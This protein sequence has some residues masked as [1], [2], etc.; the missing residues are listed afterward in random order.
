MSIN[1][2]ISNDIS[3]HIG[4]FTVNI[5]FADEITEFAL[6]DVTFAAVSGNGLTNIKRVLTGSGATYMVNISVPANV[7]GAFSVAITGQVMVDGSSERVV[8]EA[9][10]FRYD[11]IVD[12]Q[13]EFRDLQY[14]DAE[15]EIILPIQFD[16]DVLWFDRSD[17]FVER[18]AGSEAYLLEHYVRGADADYEVV[19]IP[20]EGT[21]GGFTVDITGEVIKEADLVREII[22]IDPLLISY[23]NLTPTLADVDTPVRS[24]DGWWNVSLSFEYP[25]IGFGVHSII[26]GIEHEQSFI[27]RGLSMDVMPEDVPP[28]FSDVYVF[29]DVQRMHCVGN[30]KYVDLRSEEAGRYFW[31]KLRSDED[32]EPEIL[33]K[34]INGLRA[35]SVSI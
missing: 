31:V 8:A 18:K 11:T 19:F 34:D 33:L 32:K 15:N 14:N 23:N 3:T 22:H 2:V 27:Y 9:K 7:V 16:E 1:A 35:V 17:L 21:W 12:V 28:P 6:S 26:T 13:T 24:E 4:N 5:A 20:E 29:E 30:W 25:V 10:T